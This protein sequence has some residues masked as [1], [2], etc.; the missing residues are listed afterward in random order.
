MWIWGGSSSAVNEVDPAVAVFPYTT[1]GTINGGMYF[2]NLGGELTKL[3][4]QALWQSM[5]KVLE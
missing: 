1:S 5:D 2:V 3:V 4:V